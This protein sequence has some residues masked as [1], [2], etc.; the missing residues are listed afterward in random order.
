[1]K[2][3]PPT[4]VN[5]EAGKQMRKWKWLSSAVYKVPPPREQDASCVNTNKFLPQKLRVSWKWG[6]KLQD[7]WEIDIRSNWSHRLVPWCSLHLLLSLETEPAEFGGSGI[8]DTLWGVWMSLK[9]GWSEHPQLKQALTPA[10]LPQPQA[11]KMP[12]VNSTY[13][14]QNLSSGYS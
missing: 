14:N 13:V 10:P 8:T 5:K 4:D 6:W 9:T 3:L 11:V 7:W 12:T 1:M 2:P